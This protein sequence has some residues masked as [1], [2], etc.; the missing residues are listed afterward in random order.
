M[1]IEGVGE[2]SKARAALIGFDRL[3]GRRRGLSRIGPCREQ[4]GER[5]LRRVGL[6]QA[7]L[8]LAPKELALEPLDLPLEV[9]ILDEQ[10][11]NR[12]RL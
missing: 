10:G 11:D 4:T 9:R 7:S 3:G 12:G 2:C 6:P 5:Q 8:G 1:F